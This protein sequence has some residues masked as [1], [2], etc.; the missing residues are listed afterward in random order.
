MLF[1]QS[2]QDIDGEEGDGEGNEAH[3]LQPAPEVNMILSP[4]QTQPARNGC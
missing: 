1:Y 2:P 4:L 3:S